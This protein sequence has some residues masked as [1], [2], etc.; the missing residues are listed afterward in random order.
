MPRLTRIL[1]DTTDPTA[2][3]AT[4][5]GAVTRARNAAAL[6]PDALSSTT[7]TRR[8]ALQAGGALVAIAVNPGVALTLDAGI[9]IASCP[10]SELM[11]L[12][13]TN[14][15]PHNIISL[16]AIS[17]GL[18]AVI[19]RSENLDAPEIID[20]DVFRLAHQ[21]YKSSQHSRTNPPLPHIETQIAFETIWPTLPV[22]EAL[23]TCRREDEVHYRTAYSEARREEERNIEFIVNSPE[24][25][26][27]FLQLFQALGIKVPLA[28][29]LKSAVRRLL[30]NNGRVRTIAKRIHD[31]AQDSLKDYV[32]IAD[33]ISSRH[34]HAGGALKGL[35]EQGPRSLEANPWFQAHLEHSGLIRQINHLR[36]QK[37]P[38]E[39]IQK[40]EARKKEV[41]KQIK[42]MRGEEVQDKKP[43]EP[44]TKP[45]PLSA[46]QVISRSYNVQTKRCD[47]FIYYRPSFKAEVLLVRA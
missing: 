5:R 38:K 37:A 18:E 30:T 27:Y 4:F 17:T 20:N 42:E 45:R 47:E 33:S 14:I 9:K 39:E 15:T 16:C 1:P 31:S 2:R 29:N 21:L 3:F 32:E 7:C 24:L 19:E 34:P 36:R 43:A 40:L 46:Y 23:E 25:S 12:L 41:D 10:L 22:A 11:K 26:G 28:H 6:E 8:A 13:V 35:F 44:V